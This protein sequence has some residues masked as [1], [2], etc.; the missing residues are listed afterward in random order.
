MVRA[1][2][3]A[4]AGGLPINTIKYSKKGSITGNQLYIRLQ[5][6]LDV[7]KIEDSLHADVERLVASDAEG[8]LAMT[9]KLKG[10]LMPEDEEIKMAL[11]LE[12]ACG[13]PVQDV[14]YCSNYFPLLLVPFRCCTMRRA[15]SCW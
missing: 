10:L 13:L 6:G 5:D 1:A 14:I 15:G 9:L 7:E 3:I 11:A 4:K 8:N 2:G 12:A